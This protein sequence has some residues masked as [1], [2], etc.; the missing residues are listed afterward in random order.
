MMIIS[1]VYSS[2]IQLVCIILTVHQYMFSLLVSLFSKMGCVIM[3]ID[4]IYV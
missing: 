1:H 2:F 3:K 4:Q